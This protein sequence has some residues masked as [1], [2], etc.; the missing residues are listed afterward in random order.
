MN[1]DD[2]WKVLAIVVLIVA[3]CD[4]PQQQ[5]TSSPA[6]TPMPSTMPDISGGMMSTPFLVPPLVNP[7]ILTAAEAEIAPDEQVIGV[8]YEGVPRAF[9]LSALKDMRYHVVNE[10]RGPQGFAV[11]YCDRTD[12]VRVLGS[13]KGEQLLVQ[14]AGFHNGEMQIRV[15]SVQFSQTSKDIPVPDVEFTRTTW[16]QWKEANPQTTLFVGEIRKKSGKAP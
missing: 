3:G 15:K 10:H 5:Q 13:G 2:K 16:A 14:T 8:L 12:C 4:E 11:T 7:E 9:Q 6:K 1:F